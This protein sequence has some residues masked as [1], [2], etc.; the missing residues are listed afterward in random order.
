M[1]KTPKKLTLHRET[2]PTC[3]DEPSVVGGTVYTTRPSCA[4]S[5]GLLH[6]LREL[7]RLLLN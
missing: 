7:L 2:L 1:K 3:L 6:D 5:C 4:R